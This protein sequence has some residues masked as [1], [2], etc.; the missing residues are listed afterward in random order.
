M[1]N[2]SHKDWSSILDEVLW[3]YQTVFKTPLRMSPFKIVYRKPCYLLVELE[4]KAFWAIKQLNMDWAAVGNKR[5]KLY[6]GKLKSHWSGPFE[7]VQVFSQR[8]VVIKDMKAG[9]TFK[10]NGDRLKH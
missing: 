9:V 7:V 1:A 3:A 2:P 8:A 6:P 10:V 4:H 5:L